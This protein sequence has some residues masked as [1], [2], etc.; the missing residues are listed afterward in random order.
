MQLIYLKSNLIMED[1]INVLGAVI[2]S[3]LAVL[4][5]IINTILVIFAFP[6]VQKIKI[7]SGILSLILFVF[8]V[9]LI[10]RTNKIGDILEKYKTIWVGGKYE[11]RR[12][13]KIWREIERLIDFDD[14]QSIKTAF[15]LLN[16]L[17]EEI[18]N[19]LNPQG[20][21][22]IEKV[23]LLKI[24]ELN[25]LEKDKI[26][27]GVYAYNKLKSNPAFNLESK[28]VKYFFKVYKEFFERIHVLGD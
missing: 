3:I 18:I 15:S 10:I 6:I 28:E 9:R 24:A 1:F 12:A 21:N 14:E 8:W 27:V 17:L 11:K 19:R 16:E 4:T 22:L 20:G 13:L 7:I 2:N 23:K 26:L 25:D 5:Q